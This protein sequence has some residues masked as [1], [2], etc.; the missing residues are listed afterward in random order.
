MTMTMTG[1]A[2]VTTPDRPDRP[3][4]AIPP[5]VQVVPERLSPA[6]ADAL[7]RKSRVVPG[8]AADAHGV[9]T[10]ESGRPSPTLGAPGL[11]RGLSTLPQAAFGFVQ[12]HPVAVTVIGAIGVGLLQAL[13]NA[14]ASLPAANPADDVLDPASVH[15]ERRR[16]RRT[17][18]GG[19][20]GRR[21]GA[22]A[23]AS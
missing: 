2:I 15:E 18:G 8:T 7:L 19:G 13:G 11:F 12:R 6:E 20:G 9:P 4:S 16:H 14:L 17:S 22:R 1:R 23:K 21:R 5:P 10:S 3:A